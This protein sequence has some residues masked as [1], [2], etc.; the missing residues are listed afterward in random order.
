MRRQEIQLLAAARQGDAA[1][2]CE[3]GRRYLLG[4]DGF[5]RHLQ[6]G[7]AHLTHP[8]VAASARA[9]VIVAE[10]LALEEL[11]ARGLVAKLEVAAAAGSALAQLKLGTWKLTHDADSA[12]AL[13]WFSAAGAAA[14]GGVPAARVLA[15]L[16]ARTECD[17]LAAVLQDLSTSGVLNGLAVATVAARE[18]LAQRDLPRLA[19]N[20]GVL[21]ALRA[22]MD[23]ELAELASSAVTLAEQAGTPLQA[24][25]VEF[26]HAALE[27][28]S[29]HGGHVAAY[30]LGRA[31]SG[32]RCG[33][34]D[35]QILAVAPNL[36]KGT[37]LLLRAADGGVDAAWLDLYR[38]HSDH[39]CSVANPQMARFF[40][41]KAADRGDAR[42]QRKLGALI[43][44]ES[45]SLADSERAI[46]WLYQAASKNDGSARQLLASLVLPLAGSDEEAL[47]AVEE[48]HRTD[49]WLAMRL[50]LSRRFGL[51][52]L[53]ALTVDPLQ[54]TRPWGLV[55]GQNLF[56]I[57]S[58]LSA[59]RA[60]PALSGDALDD[61]RR[62]VAFF[63]QWRGHAETTEGDIRKRS[64]RQR[65]AFEQHRLEESRFF[66]QVSSHTLESLR[67]GP[68]WAF[69]TKQPLQVAL[70]T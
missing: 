50:R 32:I 26:V 67:H 19:R 48:I 38:V 64:W 57:R 31:L 14:S 40:L 46:D 60:I 62:V 53:E 35:P 41:E 36:R 7:I 65:R 25:P 39:R 33:E 5:S 20:L 42:A 37:A 51:T 2:H 66:A 1:A 10:C 8:T 52:K 27:M 55:V 22:T 58:R 54:G 18:A 9:A 15:A 43:L 59:P 63:E 45:S 23:E 17:P 61:L 4:T 30:A 6:S 3:V 68:K 69:R 47:S 70:A 56:A 28:R 34:L 24:V 16:R 21:A 44:K 13:R 12:E 11:V 29:A 49:P